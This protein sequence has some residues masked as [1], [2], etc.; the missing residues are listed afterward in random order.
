M[1][2]HL[3]GDTPCKQDWNLGINF[4]FVCPFVAIVS[5]ADNTYYVLSDY[6]TFQALQIPLVAQSHGCLF[7][8]V[9]F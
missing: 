5:H 9:G 3:C 8:S 2:H 6:K 7:P 4:T 1:Y